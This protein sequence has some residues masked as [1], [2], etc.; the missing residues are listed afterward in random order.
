VLDELIDA[1]DQLAHA[2]EAAAADCLLSNETEPAPV[3][4]A[5]WVSRCAAST[6]AA[7]PAAAWKA[8]RADFYGPT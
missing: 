1:Y 4:A 5:A 2:A 7:R 8:L 6:C 3:T